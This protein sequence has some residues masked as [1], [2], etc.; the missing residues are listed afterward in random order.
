M[1]PCAVWTVPARAAPSVVSSEKQVT[2]PRLD[3][4]NVG[5]GLQPDSDTALHPPSQDQHR[6][7]EGI[8]SVLLL[9]RKSVEV[10]HDLDSGERHHES[11]Q[12]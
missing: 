7:A 1:S 10:A 8:E 12:R 9:D 2:G 4:S 5:T 6:V 3:E 11:K